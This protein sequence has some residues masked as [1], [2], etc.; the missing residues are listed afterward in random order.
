[1]SNKFNYDLAWLSILVVPVFYLIVGTVFIVMSGTF[2]SGLILIYSAVSSFLVGGWIFRDNASEAQIGSGMIFIVSSIIFLHTSAPIW[3]EEQYCQMQKTYFGVVLESYYEDC[4]SQG[5]FSYMMN[6]GEAQPTLLTLSS[7]ATAISL[8][9]LIGSSVGQFN[10]N[11]SSSTNQQNKLPKSKD[12]SLT[13]APGRVKIGGGG[14]TEFF[15]KNT[16]DVVKRKHIC[17]ADYTWLFQRLASDYIENDSYTSTRKR[18]S[19]E[20]VLQHLEWAI[21]KIPMVYT[22]SEKEIESGKR[23]EKIL[24]NY[25]KKLEK[26]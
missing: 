1:M 15:I 19:K 10:F 22:G 13:I 4:M 21:S 25:I 16:R 24:K 12:G 7:I 11:S 8:L 9:I 14:D 2:N 26:L 5:G 18:I 23:R 20:E 6:R 17:K 3:G